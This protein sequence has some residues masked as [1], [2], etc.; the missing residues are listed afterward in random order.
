MDSAQ[1]FTQSQP[2]LHGQDKL[3]DQLG[4]VIADNCN[5]QNAIPARLC[6]D[7][8][9]ALCLAFSDG[10]I[11]ISQ[12]MPVSWQDKDQLDHASLLEGSRHAR[13]C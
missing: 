11:K 12:I 5:A 7:F 10:T 13:S 2:M 8:N 3:V 4:G 9:K 1:Y 6:K